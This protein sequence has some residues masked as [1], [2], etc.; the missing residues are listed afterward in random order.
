MIKIVKYDNIKIFE[1]TVKN[2]GIGE[3]IASLLYENGFKNKIQIHA[4]D[5]KF[6]AAAS[7]ES[8]LKNN[9]LCANT[10]LR[11]ING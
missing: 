9:G 3:H 10:M 8:A 4:V 2:G 1:E 7:I 11:S 6:I 5:N